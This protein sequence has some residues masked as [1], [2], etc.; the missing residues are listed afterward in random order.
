MKIKLYL[1]TLLLSGLSVM[2][3]AIQAQTSCNPSCS[4]G[5]D[6]VINGNFSSGTSGFNSD[7]TLYGSCNNNRYGVFP[8]ANTPCPTFANITAH[9]GSGNFLVIDG[10]TTANRDVWYETV[11]VTAGKTYEFAYWLYPSISKPPYDAIRSQLDLR[12]NGTVIRSIDGDDYSLQWNRI[13]GTYTATTSGNIV[14]EIR[15]T[16]S[17][18]IGWDYGI[19]DVSF[20]EVETC[21]CDIAAEFS[22]LNDENC[23]YTFLSDVSAIGNTI[24]GYEWTFG[25]GYSSTDA[26]PTHYYTNSG[27]YEVCL[28][29]WAF[30]G[31]ECCYT[32]VCQQVDVDCNPEPCDINT[33]FEYSQNGCDVFFNSIGTVY[34]TTVVAYYWDFGDGTTGTNEDPSHTFPGP[35]SYEVCLTVIG[36]DYTGEGACCME[37]FCETVDVDCEAGPDPGRVAPSSNNQKISSRSS[38]LEVFPN[39]S[40]GNVTVNYTLK[41]DEQVQVFLINM[42]G[43]VAQTIQD[44]EQMARGKHTLDID[45]SELV[46]GLYIISIKYGDKLDSQKIMIRK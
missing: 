30:N 33:E 3:F 5:E 23:L 11:S 14:I 29:V 13:C 46:D 2:G 38:M 12:A 21:P 44:T 6:L 4:Y 9:G 18:S 15:Q 19:D 17:G 10:S 7:L 8:N 37:T 42:D 22:F 43:Q 24:V 1:K 20:T 31:D 32:D 41:N 27:S 45:G 39:P 35:G 16:N 25:D 26:T 40:S 36:K 28:K 34:N